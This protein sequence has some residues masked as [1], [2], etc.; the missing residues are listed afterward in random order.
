MNV[1]ICGIN[2]KMG[3]R[4]YEI[5]RSNP[6]IEKI[7]GI[8]SAKDK[9]EFLLIYDDLSSLILNNKIDIL[10]D[11]SNKDYSYP[12]ILEALKNNIKVISGTTGFDEKD[13][14]FLK[15]IALENKISFCWS[16][17]FAKGSAILSKIIELLKNEF[18]QVDLIEAHSNTKKDKPSGTAKVLSK[19]INI[20]N[21]DIQVLRLNNVN[22]THCLIFKDEYEKIVINYE[23]LDKRAFIEGFLKSF[24]KICGKDLIVS[25]SLESF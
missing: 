12:F 25:C 24:D 4:I 13:I 11:F 22:A 19:I 9:S 21:A 18:K 15:E 23:V 3:T 20:D 5:L 8:D 2:G 7:F 1:A 10:I 14:L 17:N 6:L 16:S